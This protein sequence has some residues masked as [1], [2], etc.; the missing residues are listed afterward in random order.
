MRTFALSVVW[1]GLVAC[2]KAPAKDDAPVAS[3][4]PPAAAAAPAAPSVSTPAS[5]AAE[6]ASATPSVTERKYAIVGVAANDVLNV[7]EKPD[8]GSKKVYSYAPS[9]KGIR[10]TGEHV[11]KGGTPWVEVVFEGGKGWVNRLYLSEQHPGGGCN[12]PALTA[13]IRAFMRAVVAADGAALKAVVSPLRGLS[14]RP[15]EKVLKFPYAQVETMFSSPTIL[16]LGPG[17]GGGPDLTGTFKEQLQPQLVKAVSGKG[18]KEV[19]G[20]LLTGSSTSMPPTLEQFPNVTPVSFHYA[21]PEGG[22]GWV[23]WVGSIEYVDGKPYFSAL[24]EFQWEP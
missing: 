23:T 9:S 21:D 20:K 10:T 15:G 7:R 12:D 2:N 11:E 18:A 24:D 13:V 1:L 8:A 6:G 4:T 22:I 5:A 14:V 19:C 17:G 16:N 3:A